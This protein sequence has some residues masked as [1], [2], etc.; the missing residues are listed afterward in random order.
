ME[1][2]GRAA[3]R[4]H[5][6]VTQ[7]LSPTRATEFEFRAVEDGELR[8]ANAVFLEAMHEERPNDEK[9]AISRKVY[10]PG[11][12]HGAFA[13]STVVGT[14][15]SFASD[16]TVPGGAIVP[17]AGVSGVGVRTDYRRRG[18]LTGL[19]RQQL[20][21]FAA[22]GEVLAT[23]H[24]SEPM[25]YG[26]FGYGLAT[27][28]RTTRVRPRRARVRP[29][30]PTSGTTRILTRDEAL[31]LL[32]GAY[33]RLRPARA[34]MMARPPSWWVLCYEFRLDHATLRVAAHHD[35]EGRID[36]FL[37]YRPARYPS[38]DPRTGSAIEVLDFI[39]ASQAVENDLWR[40]LV[41]IDLV[42]LI[43]VYVRPSDDPLEAI[44]VDSHA[45]RGERD[46]E[47]WLRIVDVPAALAARTYGAADPV[48]VEV[49]DP[50][51]PNNS[52]RYLI[53]PHGTDRTEAPAAL[54]LGVEALGMA[55]LGAWPLSQLAATGWLTAHDPAALPAADRLFA[56]D[57]P[58][59]C[60]SLF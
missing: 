22:A 27:T 40:F 59:W 25:I 26:R 34:G 23:L 17:M 43:T 3:G 41:G 9:W 1:S 7:T 28:A 47:L 12:T 50:L 21:E 4:H 19:M 20:G 49:V 24:A 38:D 2:R 39:G 60:G 36:G 16:L 13:G 45:V 52:G 44:L 11:R 18:V 15:M 46:D 55:Y 53:S 29:E 57:R 58:S 10:E 31:T 5:R 6:P 37:A 32:P 35:G 48:V 14:T 51:L 33:E 8:E 30:V 56:T 54:T 42:E